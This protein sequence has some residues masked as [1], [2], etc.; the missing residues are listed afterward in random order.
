MRPKVVDQIVSAHTAAEIGCARN[1]EVA[2]NWQRPKTAWYDRLMP[3]VKLIV[4]ANEPAIFFASVQ[5]AENWVEAV[6]VEDG[7]R[8]LRS[9][10]TVNSTRLAPT[11]L[12]STLMKQGK[13][14]SP[15]P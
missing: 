15:K 10:P 8:A 5:D 14:R 11:A 3:Q 1:L 9:D 2:D 4:A 6:D 13:R 12:G 7:S